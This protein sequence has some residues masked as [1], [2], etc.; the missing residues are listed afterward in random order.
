MI[1]KGS[2]GNID[3]EHEVQAIIDRIQTD[4]KNDTCITVPGS[5]L[6]FSQNGQKLCEIDG[7]VIYPQRN[8]KQIIILEAKNTDANPGHGAKCLAKKMKQLGWKYDRKQILVT[9][10]D[11]SYNFSVGEEVTK[12]I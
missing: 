7:I 1:L 6:V 2:S 11:A 8:D 12:N 10:H 5:T 3:E 4:Q 9:E